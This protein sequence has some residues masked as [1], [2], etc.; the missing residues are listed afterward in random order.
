MTQRLDLCSLRERAEKPAFLGEFLLL[1]DP[2]DSHPLA[3]TPGLFFFPNKQHLFC[4]WC[5]ICFPYHSIHFITTL[6]AAL[7]EVGCSASR[8]S[9]AGFSIP[10]L[11]L[12]AHLAITLLFHT[13]PSH[14]LY[15]ILGQIT[16]KLEW[17]L[18]KKK[19][20]N[21]FKVQLKNWSDMWAKT[22]QCGRIQSTQKHTTTAHS[23]AMKSDAIVS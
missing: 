21:I 12:G 7:D 19:K 2:H 4:L 8:R 14:L 23:L 20:P 9:T 17:D 22:Q 1:N 13:T 16:E 5:F 6:E 11:H 15:I 18:S 10:Q 3:Q